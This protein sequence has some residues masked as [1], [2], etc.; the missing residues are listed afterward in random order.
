MYFRFR[1]LCLEND[2]IQRHQLKGNLQSTSL[3][4]K[5]PQ[6]TSKS[7]RKKTSE[8]EHN[9]DSTFN[10]LRPVDNEYE[11]NLIEFFEKEQVEI[12]EEKLVKIE[13]LDKANVEVE[14][15]KG[16]KIEAQIRQII[17][18]TLTKEQAQAENIIIHIQ[19]DDEE[20]ETLTKLTELKLPILIK[21]VT[22]KDTAPT[23]K[24]VI[25]DYDKDLNN[26]EEYFS[27]GAMSDIG[28]FEATSCSYIPGFEFC[29]LDGYVFEY[30]LCKGK[31][32]YIELFVFI[33]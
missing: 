33:I 21:P 11:E 16:E 24:N 18:G 20:N 22:P 28:I 5:H 7:K 30:R 6:A 4:R 31:V 14:I 19:N 32:R 3:K 10:D 17:E 26:T 27:K 1:K 8:S 29:I 9:I 2:K 15:S 23:P 25:I 13:N 12:E